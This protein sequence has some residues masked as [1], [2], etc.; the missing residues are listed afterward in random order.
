MGQHVSNKLKLKI[1]SGEFVDL[2]SLLRKP[3]DPEDITK[4]LV[5]KDNKIVVD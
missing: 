1:A 5:M 4:Q 2:A 3:I